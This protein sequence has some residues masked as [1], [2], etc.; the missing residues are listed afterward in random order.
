MKKVK[1]ISSIDTAIRIYFEHPELGNSQIK[2]LFGS[3][4]NSTISAYKKAVL[5]EQ[6]KRGVKTSYWNAINT[7]VAYEVWGIDVEDLIKRREKLKKLG[8]SA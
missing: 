5:E 8:F 2:E 6:A 4:G 1:Q 3:I 7:E